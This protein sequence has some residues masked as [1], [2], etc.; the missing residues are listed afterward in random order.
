LEKDEEKEVFETRIA[1]KESII[2]GSYFTI[3]FL[4]KNVFDPTLRAAKVSSIPPI[5]RK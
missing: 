3:K 5:V 1:G 4:R 2:I